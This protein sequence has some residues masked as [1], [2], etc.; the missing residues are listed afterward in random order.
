LLPQISSTLRPSKD[1]IGEKL[2]GNY[3]KFLEE[4]K[5]WLPVQYSD[6]YRA[7]EVDGFHVES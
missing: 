2:F 5:K 1:V 6:W 4:V 7:T 3:D